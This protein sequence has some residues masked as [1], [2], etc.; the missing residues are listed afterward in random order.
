MYLPTLESKVNSANNVRRF[1]RRLLAWYDQNK[2]DLPWRKDRD[3]YR[4]W[5]SEIMLQQT[6]VAAVIEH[7]QRFLRKF[8]SVEKLAAAREAS[9][10]AAWSGLGYYRRARMLHAT[11]KQ[12]EQEHDGQFP[13]TAEGLRALPGIGRYTAA[14][15]ASIAFG[16]A[17]AVVDGNV[18]RVVQRLRGKKLAGESLWQEAENLLS[19]K[20]PGDF[21]QALME[22]GATVCLPR[23]PQCVV[24]PVGEFCIARGELK[25][26]AK[27]PA[28]KKR[29]VSYALDSRDGRVFM[30]QR[31]LDAPLMAGMWELPEITHPN[32]TQPLRT[33]RHSITVTNYTVHVIK[34]PAPKDHPGKWISTSKL[35][36]IPVTG[37]TR[38]ILKAEGLML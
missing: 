3:P 13:S 12:I 15:I 1:R 36:Q 27:K 7:Y 18:E 34:S 25:S 9:V 32:G 26:A 38:K 28:Q 19:P 33:L 16:Q 14:A 21:N 17:V 22:L 23:Q 4:V 29:A 8:P 10:L 6:R 37:L 24:C 5:L 30:V 20:R 31:P 11:A 35:K 2:R